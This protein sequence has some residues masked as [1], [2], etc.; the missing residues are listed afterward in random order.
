[1]LSTGIASSPDPTAWE[2]FARNL[3]ASAL[4]KS[5]KIEFRLITDDFDAI[6]YEGWYIEDVEVL[7]RP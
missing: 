2:K 4:G 5:I 3:P 7:V 1:V 6:D